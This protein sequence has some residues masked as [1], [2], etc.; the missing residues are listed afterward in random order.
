M[1]SSAVVD[2]RDVSVSLGG[3]LVLD[4][5]S[6]SGRPGETVALTGVNGAGKSTLIR[7]V[8]GM[9]RPTSGSVT[10]FGAVP[11]TGRR[12]WRLVASVAEEPAWYPGRW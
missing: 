4:R 8:T 10:V 5:V 7:C 1:G 2:V 3:S 9:Q 6:V 11:D 12:F